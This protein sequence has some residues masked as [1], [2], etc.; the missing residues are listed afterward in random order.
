LTINKK[1]FRSILLALTFGALVTVAPASA[2]SI[3]LS[4]SPTVGA[5]TTVDVGGTAWQIG[6][7]TVSGTLTN[8]I[9]TLAGDSGSDSFLNVNGQNFCSPSCSSI[10]GSGVIDVTVTPTI[11]G[12]P[13]QTALTFQGSIVDNGGNFS[14][15]FGNQ[16]STTCTTNCYNTGHGDTITAAQT[17]VGGYTV[18]TQNGINYEIATSTSIT[19]TKIIN[20]VGGFVGVVSAPEPATYATTGLGIALLG[21][22]L[23]R[24]KR[25]S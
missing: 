8:G 18:L 11:N 25:N 21:F 17:I 9:L 4:V 15:Y 10:T 13:A 1:N 12:G 24:K 16:G 6:G 22:F 19:P 23:R 2:T 14:L 20:Y 5:P 7:Y 3:G